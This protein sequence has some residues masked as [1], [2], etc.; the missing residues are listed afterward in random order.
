MQDRGDTFDGQF[1]GRKEI[2]GGG[3]K[4]LYLGL[5]FIV[6]WGLRK[7]ILFTQSVSTSVVPTSIINYSL[8]SH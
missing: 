2:R 3:R 1:D 5:Y 4:I 7:K 8:C 6:R